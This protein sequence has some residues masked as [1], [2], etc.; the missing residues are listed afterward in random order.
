MKRL[1]ASG[2]AI[3]KGALDPDACAL[4]SCYVEVQ[5]LNLGHFLLDRSAR[6]LDRYADPLGEALLLRLQ[7]LLERRTGWPLLPTYSLLRV[8]Q[9]GAR[10]ALHTDRPSCE[11]SA[12]LTIDYDAPAPWPLLFSRGGR[13]VPVTLARGDLVL[14][15][16]QEVPHGRP[17]LEGAW[18]I[19]LFLHYVRA[20][21]PNA[22]RK[23][24]GRPFIGATAARRGPGRRPYR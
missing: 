10:L 21:G 20:D 13:K 16:G 24:D 2:Y 12:S 15:L 22:H 14:Y 23:F 8:Y 11:V 3:V 18:W 17:P 1:P 7:P 6:R 4:I 19:Q 9:Q 5:K